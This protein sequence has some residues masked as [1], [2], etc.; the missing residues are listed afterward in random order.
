MEIA[1]ILKVLKEKCGIGKIGLAEEMQILLADNEALYEDTNKKNALLEAYCKQ[2]GHTI[3]GNKIEVNIDMLILNIESK[4]DWMIQHIRGN[5]WVTNKEGYSWYNGYYDNHGQSVEGDYETGVRMILTGQVFTIMSNIATNDQVTEI[6]KAADKYLYNEAVGGYRLNT[7][8]NELKTDLGRLFGF[9]YGHKENG[10]V[11]C[12]MA[13]MYANALYQRNFIKEGF[14]VINTLYKHCIDFEKSRIY[15][16]VPEY[17]NEKGRGMYHYLT[18]S[19]SWLMLT[20]VTEMFG[21]KGD[22]GNLSFRPKLLLEQ[23]NKEN[24]ACIEMTFAGRT[25]QIEYCNA[26]HK[27]YQSYEVKQILIDE[28]PYTFKNDNPVIERQDIEA[29]DSMKEHIIQVILE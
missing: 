24:K 8:F 21:A 28:I 22:L 4:A 12:H 9:A 13:I 29:L 1:K 11:F 25:L 7:N 18:G 20:V 19:A 6:I 5:E 10:A 26:L 27:E 17:I 3:T 16:G 15:P 2:V 23:F 14:K